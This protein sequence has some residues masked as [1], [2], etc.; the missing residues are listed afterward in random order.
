MHHEVTIICDDI[1]QETGRK[2]SLMGIYDDAVVVKQVPVRLAKVCL[3]QRWA[4]ANLRPG[5]RVR[6]EIAGDAISQQ[7]SVYCE[8]DKAHFNP[9][10]TKAQLMIALA[11]FDIIRAGGIEFRTYLSGSDEPAHRHKIEIRCDPDLAASLVRLRGGAQLAQ[12]KESSKFAEF[13]KPC[14]PAKKSLSLG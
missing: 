2:L 6:V 9:A 3:F 14:S 12:L 7:V 8:T 1:R 5:E 13:S 4:E 11:P 10:S